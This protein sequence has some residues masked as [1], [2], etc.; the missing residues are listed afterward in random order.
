MEE[1]LT[2]DDEEAPE[3][4]EGLFLGVVDDAVVGDEDVSAT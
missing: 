2:L 3:A 4:V 1:D